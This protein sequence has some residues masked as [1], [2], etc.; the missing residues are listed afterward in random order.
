[1]LSF[2]EKI[3]QIIFPFSE[4]ETEQFLVD[5]SIHSIKAMFKFN[6]L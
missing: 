3:E 6:L 5:V 4:I 2:G 1:M